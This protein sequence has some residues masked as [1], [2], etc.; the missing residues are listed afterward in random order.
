MGQ[1]LDMK[2]GQPLDKKALI[3][4]VIRAEWSMFQKVRSATPAAC[5]QSPEQFKSIRGSLFSTWNEALLASYLGDLEQA[6]QSGQNLMME[7]YARM[8]D[9]FERQ[10]PDPMIGAIVN[11]ERRWQ[12]EL[13]SRYPALY[14]RVCRKNNER[15][16]GSDFSKYLQCELETYSPATIELYFCYVN[17]ACKDANN[18]AVQ[19]LDYL[20]RS[21]G[22]A[23]IGHAEE[24]VGAGENG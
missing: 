12:R 5:Q 10:T 24:V 4:A 2:P 16:D 23:D 1:C 7:K 17:Q 9:M 8:D 13:E 14:R 19:A 3:Q 18:L 11:I 20:V 22:F 21:N 15:D 6:S